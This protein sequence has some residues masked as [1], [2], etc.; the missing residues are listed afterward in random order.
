M[1][2]FTRL[3]QEAARCSRS[4]YFLGGRFPH[5]EDHRAEEPPFHGGF[6]TWKADAFCLIISLS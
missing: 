1:A 5:R 3:N 6:F 4:L 2:E